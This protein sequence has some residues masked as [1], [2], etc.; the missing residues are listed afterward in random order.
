MSHTKMHEHEIDID[1]EL[2]QELVSAQFPEWANL[3]I[4]PVKSSGTDN[5]LYRLGTELCVRLPRIALAAQGIEI[6]H[7]W[8]PFL[9]PKLSLPIPVPLAQGKPYERY[10]WPWSIYEWIE[11]E[12]AFN[13]PIDDNPQAPIALAQFI[14]T[15]Q[16]IG[17]AGAPLSRR[18]VPLATLDTEVHTAIKSLHGVVDTKAIT[19]VW[20]ECLAAPVWDKPAVWSHGDLLPGNILVRNGQVNAIL[21]FSSV[22]IGDPAIDMIPAWSIFTS[23]TRSIF[24]AH[25]GVDDATWMRG[26]GWA[27]AIAVI[28]IPYYQQSNP[29]LVAVAHRI[30]QEILAERN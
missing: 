7:K 14:H 20:D 23:N 8:L 3:D 2:V 21:D 17:P 19:A 22:G 26:R 4:K 15:L 11:G 29:E 25:L 12:N 5:A 27:L 6:E 28:L 18:G 16:Q 24:R 1:I 13:K 30:I 9:A 10:L